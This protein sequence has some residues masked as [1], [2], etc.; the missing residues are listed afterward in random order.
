M[1]GKKLSP[2]LEEIEL[3]ILDY[4]VNIGLK[5]NFTPEAFRAAIKIFMSV[6]TDKIWELQETERMDIETREKMITKAGNEFRKLIKIYTGIDTFN[7]YKETVI[8]K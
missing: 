6:F 1:I 7:L 4:E 2:I 3:A 8:N 5:P